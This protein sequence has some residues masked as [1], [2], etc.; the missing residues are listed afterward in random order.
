MISDKPIVGL[1]QRRQF[2]GWHEKSNR[3]THSRSPF[4][5]AA[6]LQPEYHVM[7][8]RRRHTEISLHIGLRRRSA[9]HLFVVVNERQILALFL[10]EGFHLPIR[11]L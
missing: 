3:S 10:R 6:S 8:R 11:K 7:D 5:E 4:D 9:V 1:L 2:R